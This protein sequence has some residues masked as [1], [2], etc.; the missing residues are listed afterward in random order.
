MRGSQRHHVSG[1]A[2]MSLLRQHSLS[3]RRATTL[4]ELS[5][6]CRV[7]YSAVA[8]DTATNT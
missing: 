8:T 7:A 3:P 1:E 5:V 6:N 4:R 2:G